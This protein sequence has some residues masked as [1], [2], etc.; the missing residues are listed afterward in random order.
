MQEC[1]DTAWSRPSTTATLSGEYVNPISL[2]RSLLQYSPAYALSQDNLIDSS[3]PTSLQPQA[4]LCPPAKDALKDSL[5]ARGCSSLLPS[6]DSLLLDNTLSSSTA[7]RQLMTSQSA[8]VTRGWG[9]RSRGVQQRGQQ[10]GDTL[11]V[12]GPSWL[13]GAGEGGGGLEA[14]RWQVNLSRAQSIEGELWTFSNM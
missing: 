13:H 5:L 6:K 3:V 9:A 14:R 8:H 7:K 11:A 10:A 12:S 4:T 2:N 1:I